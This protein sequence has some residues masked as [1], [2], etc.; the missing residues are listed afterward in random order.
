MEFDRFTLCSVW[1]DMVRMTESFGLG[2]DT[3]SAPAPIDW[4]THTMYQGR[5]VQCTKQGLN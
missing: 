5:I 4:G 2:P 3:A 1:H